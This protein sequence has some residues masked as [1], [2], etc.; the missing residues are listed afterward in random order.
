MGLLC[1]VNSHCHFC[2]KVC[3]ATG[4]W[5]SIR[6]K[7][8]WNCS[9]A[10]HLIPV[11]NVPCLPVVMPLQVKDNRKPSCGKCTSN[12][13]AFIYRVESYTVIQADGS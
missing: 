10:Q 4:N 3:E 7:C 6:S 1:A 9:H 2:T 13:T 12:G 5:V 11:Y 8:K